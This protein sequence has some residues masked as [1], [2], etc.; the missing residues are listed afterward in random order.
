MIPVA[1]HP[2]ERTLAMNLHA[3]MLAR[4]Q[5]LRQ[6]GRNLNN[7]MV[8]GL[9]KDAILKGGR[10]LGLLGR[11]NVLT[12]DSEDEMSVLMDHILHDDLRGGENFV[13]RSLAESPPPEGT[14][15]R[16]VLE[17]QARARYSLFRAIAIER[18]VGVTIEDA[19]RGGQEF[20]V[21]INFSRSVPTGAMLA[22]RV[23]KPEGILMTTGAGLPVDGE[24][25]LR[26]TEEIEQTFDPAR[27]DFSD[28]SPRQAADLATLIIRSCL[29]TG[30]GARIRYAD[31]PGGGESA[32]RPVTGP[33]RGPKI[34]RNEPCPCG[35]GKKYKHCCGINA[36]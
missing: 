27:I 15:E 33:R 35:S 2:S 24:A 29:A 25:L 11:G 23:F 14:D 26:I 8:E 1:G 17:A 32:R 12:L 4:Y 36:T 28:L 18:G 9:P 20:L 13:Q 5:T 31:P 34:G 6:V 30:A 10:N 7:R 22:M 16:L 19:L 21:D 3:H